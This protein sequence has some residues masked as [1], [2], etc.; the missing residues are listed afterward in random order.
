MTTSGGGAGRR[1]RAHDEPDRDA[2]AFAP[3]DLD[4][5]RPFPGEG[6]VAFDGERVGLCFLRTVLHVQRVHVLDR[7]VPVLAIQSRAV[8]RDVERERV[9]VRDLPGEDARYDEEHGEIGD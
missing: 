8:A 1:V 7:A 9:P 4:L 6:R 3:R 2:L 5:L